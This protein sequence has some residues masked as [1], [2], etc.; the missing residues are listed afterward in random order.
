MYKQT[1]CKNRKQKRDQER[2]RV[3]YNA[4]TMK[5]FD[6]YMQMK[7]YYTFREPFPV[8]Q[9]DAFAN[10]ALFNQWKMRYISE[11]LDITGSL[12]KEF[13]KPI[14]KEAAITAIASTL[15]HEREQHDETKNT[16]HNIEITLIDEEGTNAD[17]DHTISDPV[18][19]TKS[20]KIEPERKSRR[21]K[22]RRFKTYEELKISS[23]LKDTYR[24]D[25]T[26]SLTISNVHYSYSFPVSSSRSE[27]VLRK[28]SHHS[29]FCHIPSLVNEIIS[30]RDPDY[31]KELQLHAAIVKCDCL[32]MFKI[33]P[34][35]DLVTD[36]FLSTRYASDFAT[37][38]GDWRTASVDYS[39][40]SLLSPTEW[41]KILHLV[42][43]CDHEIKYP[44]EVWTIRQYRRPRGCFNLHP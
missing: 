4:I 22:W 18:F 36:C 43:R 26:R 33:E 23:E 29:K 21:Q 13:S 19:I 30:N 35:Y 14:I 38:H 27:T 25:Q 1:S 8:E 5:N 31:K 32:L 10:N 20:G 28:Q 3:Y 42:D 6:M 7:L 40:L 44:T 12:V 15:V 34:K 39:Q 24:D 17:S 11:V 16:V 2:A 37:I 9:D 41:L